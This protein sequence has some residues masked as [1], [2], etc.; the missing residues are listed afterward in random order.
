MKYLGA[1]RLG[2]KEAISYRFET[3]I[4]GVVAFIR[5]G[6][7]YVIWG[8]VFAA[9]G[10][11]T[12]RGFTLSGMINYYVLAAIISWFTWSYIDSDITEG[13]RNGSLIIDVLRPVKFFFLYLSIIAGHKIMRIFVQAIPMALVAVLLFKLSTSPIYFFLF[14]I[15]ILIAMFIAFSFSYL[16]GLSAFWLTKTGGLFRIRRGVQGLLEGQLVPLSLFPAGLQSIFAFLPFQYM[17]FVPAQ[18]FLQKFTLAES[19]E[20]ITLQLIWAII[21]YSLAAIAWRRARKRFEAVGT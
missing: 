9:M 13:V 19:L 21:I 12:I 1:V 3:A 14:V 8:A 18:I 4:Y 2:L 16:F 10:A 11:E 7:W 15:S 20:K 17:M 6:I 5:I